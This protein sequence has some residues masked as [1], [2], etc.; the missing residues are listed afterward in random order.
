MG[1]M[2]EETKGS[3]G[4]EGRVILRE[5]DFRVEF[6][7]SLVLFY[8]GTC[9]FCSRSVRL[10]KWMDRRKVVDFAPLQGDLS[11]EMGLSHFADEE[12]GSL[13]LLRED[14]GERFFRSEACIE[15]GKAIGQPWKFLAL[16]CGLFP[17]GLRDGI[18]KFIAKHRYL[19]AGKS[20][21]C[22]LPEDDFRRRLRK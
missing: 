8:D 11:E 10:V 22:E 19:I 13:V 6:G 14:D 21:A 2:D 7:V 4:I 20:D 12:E 9:G 5:S 16:G 15:L 17:K 18:Y 1:C 3:F